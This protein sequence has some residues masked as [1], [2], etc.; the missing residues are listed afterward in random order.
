MPGATPEEALVASDARVEELKL[1][2]KNFWKVLIQ[3]IA[4]GDSETVFTL[5]QA[6]IATAGMIE[7]FSVDAFISAHFVQK[8]EAQRAELARL[9]AV[10]LAS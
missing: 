5:K 8:F 3:A 6:M 4:D 7:A 1:H 9:E 10:C 2:Q